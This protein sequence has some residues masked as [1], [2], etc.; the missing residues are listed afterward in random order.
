MSQLVHRGR[1]YIH[2][3]PAY[4]SVLQL[5]SY[6]VLNNVILKISPKMKYGRY[7][8]DGCA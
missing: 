8:R 1:G 7:R 4:V 6:L 3:K 5:T 2:V